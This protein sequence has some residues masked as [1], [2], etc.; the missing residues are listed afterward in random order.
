MSKIV[1]GPLPI[2]ITPPLLWLLRKLVEHLP[3]IVLPQALALLDQVMDPKT[4][5]WR[6]AAIAAVLIELVALVNASVPVAL[7]V[8]FA[9]LNAAFNS[10]GSQ[11]RVE[12][13]EQ[14]SVG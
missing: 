13:R 12:E 9:V 7:I 8:R 11:R 14:A 2:P 3:A 10:Q 5:S 1:I 6:R 4:P